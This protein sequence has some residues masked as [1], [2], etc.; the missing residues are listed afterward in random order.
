[1][2]APYKRCH[3]VRDPEARKQWAASK[4]NRCQACSR[5]PDWLGV[6]THHIIRGVGR[7]DEAANMIR[8]CNDCHGR[9]H[10]DP[11]DGRL[12][13]GMVAMLK[14][15]ADPDEFDMPRLMELKGGPV[16]LTEPPAWL[17]AKW[18]RR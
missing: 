5:R 15:F 12:T 16:E 4:P 9:V 7:S 14:W 1:M 18:R 8:L 10:D 17:V 11:Q 6:Q 13:L 3:P 2:R